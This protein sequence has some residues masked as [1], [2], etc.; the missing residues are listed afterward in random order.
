M[1]TSS[2]NTCTASRSYTVDVAEP[3]LGVSPSTA[4]CLGAAATLTAGPGSGIVW[5]PGGSNFPSVSVSPSVT[6]VYSVNASVVTGSI[7]CPASNTVLVTVNPNP[8]VSVTA[9]STVICKSNTLLITASGASSYSW[10]TNATTPVI[11]FSSGV[12]T[13]H[14]ITATGTD[15]NGCKGTGGL[16]VKVN[17][18]NA[19]GE[20]DA[21][22]SISIYP[23]PSGG[24]F[25]IKGESAATVTFFNALGQQAGVIQLDARNG[26]LAELSGLAEGVYVVR[27]Q[28]GANIITKTVIVNH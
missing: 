2:S 25:F 9:P 6:T 20:L 8:T 18:C 19:I 10:S 4:I 3:V 17:S 22:G 14:S 27:V 7:S 16:Q 13:T 28:A 11:T 1:G 5:S 26:Y 23:N 21:A 15:A 24:T 12:V